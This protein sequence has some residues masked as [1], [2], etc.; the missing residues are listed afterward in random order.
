[1]ID[2]D[3]KTFFK[4]SV[5]YEEKLGEICLPPEV[6]SAAFSYFFNSLLLLLLLS[7]TYLLLQTMWQDTVLK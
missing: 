1:M 2:I 6:R 4:K 5:K 7:S 3:W